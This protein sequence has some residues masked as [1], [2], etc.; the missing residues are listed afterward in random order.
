MHYTIFNTCY[1][2]LRIRDVYTGSRI[3]IFPSRMQGQKD[4]G[5]GSASKNLSIFNPK[6]L[7]LSY[8]K[9]YLGC[10]SRIWFFSPSRTQRS[11]KHRILDPRSGYATLLLFHLSS[12][13]NY[14]GCSSRIRIF[15]LSRIQRS[16]KHRIPDPRSG[17]AT[18]LLFHCFGGCWNWIQNSWNVRR[19]K[20]R[21]GHPSTTWLQLIYSHCLSLY[22]ENQLKRWAWKVKRM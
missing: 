5:S 13:K 20:N 4:P 12:R 19:A 11:K 8:R 6:K 10:S 18:L 15:S 1:S 14:L 9:N 2:V 21:Q 17:Y 16:K 3:R 22:F 7:F